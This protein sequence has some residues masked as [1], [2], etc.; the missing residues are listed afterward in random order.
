MGTMLNWLGPQR[1]TWLV[2][3]LIATGLASLVLQLAFAE[4]TW[5]QSAQTALVLLFLAGAFWI[6]SGVLSPFTKRRLAF[7]VLPALGALA[8]AV[9]LPDFLFLFL[10]AALGWLFAAQMLMRN[11]DKREY[12]LAVKALRKGEYQQAIDHINPL[13]Q[14]EPEVAEHYAFRAQLHRLNDDPKRARQDYEQVLALDPKSSVGANGMSEVSLQNGDLTE[15]RRWAELAYQN[16]P[17]DWVAPYNLGMILERAGDDK[18]AEKALREALAL[19]IPESRHRFLSYFWLSR[20][21]HRQGKPDEAQK[22]V[23]ELKDEKTGFKEWQTILESKEAA[24][25]RTLLQQDV[26]LAGRLMDGSSLEEVF[27]AA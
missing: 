14:Q 13:I 10:G 22:M 8:L 18:G 27:N 23:A 3:L 4:E 1:R 25:L 26:R 15:A 20:L 11:M 7:T 2:G 12:K 5:S 16:A 19:K 24:T 6:V 21:L 9:L 17:Q